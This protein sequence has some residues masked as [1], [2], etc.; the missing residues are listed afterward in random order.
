MEEKGQAKPKVVILTAGKGSRLNERTKYFNKALLRVGN[1][2]VISHTIDKFN[3]D[4]EFVIALGYKGSIVRQYL[5]VAHPEKKFTF[6]E[7]DKYSEPGAGP[8]YALLKCREKLQCPFYF[9]SCD[10][11]ISSLFT[12]P[13]IE[14]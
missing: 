13:Y 3:D 14:L 8:G 4:T 10:S 9:V 12:F 11:I 2:A 5:E 6:V 7:V 1:K